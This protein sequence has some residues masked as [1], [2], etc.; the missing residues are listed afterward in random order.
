MTSA[1]IALCKELIYEHFGS[2][3]VIVANQIL[4]EP[5]TLVELRRN[6]IKQLTIGEI[7]EIL[8]IFDHHQ[9]LTYSTGKFMTYFMITEHVIRFA[10]V[11]R[12]LKDIQNFFGKY[13]V[14]IV[15]FLVTRGQTSMSDCV[16]NVTQ[17]LDGDISD[18]TTTFRK[19]AEQNVINRRATVLNND[20]G[21][22]TY[23]QN[24]D[25]FECPI[26]ICDG[27]EKDIVIDGPNGIKKTK[28]VFDDSDNDI[29]WTL[30]WRRCDFLVRDSQITQLLVLFAPTHTE[31]IGVISA[32]MRIGNTRNNLE[33]VCSQPISAFDVIK[34]AKISNAKSQECMD[35]LRCLSEESN[36]VV[37]RMGEGSG[38]LYV[39]DYEKAIE[40]LLIRNV[41]AF[42]RERIDDRAARIFC[43]LIKKGY[44]EEDQIERHAMIPS[45]E[46]KEVC[47][48]LLNESLIEL[49]H[50]SKTSDFAPSK[51]T[52]LYSVN[53][54]HVADYLYMY[55]LQALRNLIHRRHAQA[56]KHRNLTVRVLKRDY[57]VETIKND[58]NL[59]EE[60]KELQIQEAND[61]FLIGDDASIYEKLKKNENGLFAR[62]IEAEGIAFA[63][64]QLLKFK[65]PMKIGP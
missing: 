44:L 18:I 4:S 6:L 37:K 39:I 53:L 35:L 21:Y 1:E 49:R 42:I 24:E 23:V 40:E 41:Q 47:S 57:I 20:L 22:P 60:D 59:S 25:V 30:N 43:L 46:A 64:I 36:G 58:A 45:K 27:K 16:R 55:C 26:I 56:E 11:P 17:K 5:L 50:I 34:A 54:K 9:I 62:E 12:L 28:K 63:A 32:L 15:Q 31:T 10:R 8:L 13:G 61:T 2:K 51:T 38:G 65:N 7:R 33:A 14:G 48:L 3:S 29:L 19:L 52:Y